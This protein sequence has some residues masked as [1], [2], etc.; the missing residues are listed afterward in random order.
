[1]SADDIIHQSTRLRIMA[2][3]NTLERREAL[4]F[5]QLKAMIETTDGNL[6]AHLDTLAKAGYVDVEKLFVGRRPRTRIRAT[7]I[8]R[9]AFRGHVAFLRKI[10]GEAEATRGRK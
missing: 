7:T 1:M 9:R 5:T 8:G 2:A 10:I 4:E 6:G 3:L